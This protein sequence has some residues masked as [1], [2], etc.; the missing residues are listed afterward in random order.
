MT[1]TITNISHDCGEV[2]DAV[3]GGTTAVTGILQRA[4]AF[5]ASLAGTSVGYDTIVRPLA[6]AMVCNQVLGGV[7]SVN[8]T[9]GSLSVGNKNIVAM[10]RYFKNEARTAAIIKGISIDGYRILFQDSA[11]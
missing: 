6:D 1:V 2:Y 7:D 10:Q 4:T 9:I 11:Q 5:I 8:K 3:D